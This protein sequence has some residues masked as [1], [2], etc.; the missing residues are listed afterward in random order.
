MKS[1]DFTVY[2]IAGMTEETFSPLIMVGN[3]YDRIQASY[4]W[5]E[6]S[7]QGINQVSD[8]IEN[9]KKKNSHQLSNEL[10]CLYPNIHP[11]SGF[12]GLH[13]FL[14]EKRHRLMI[15]EALEQACS[16]ENFSHYGV[17]IRLYDGQIE[18]QAS[19]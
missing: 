13:S 19:W 2:L 6:L 8:L 9:V 11:E 3:P 18:M 12:D 17:R 5:R 10:Y 14:Y 15:K 16:K 4:T 1:L 7:E